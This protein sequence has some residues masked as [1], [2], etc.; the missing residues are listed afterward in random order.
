[1]RSEETALC[2]TP[3]SFQLTL[4]QLLGL[5]VLDIV[6]RRLSILREVEESLQI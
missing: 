2:F 6:Y 4:G 5:C 1:M 3:L